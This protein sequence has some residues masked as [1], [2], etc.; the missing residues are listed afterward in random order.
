MSPI[1]YVTEVHSLMFS[2]ENLNCIWYDVV[3]TTE[4]IVRFSSTNRDVMK[5]DL[6]SGP[7]ISCWARCGIFRRDVKTSLFFWHKIFDH[8]ACLSLYLLFGSP[9]LFLLILHF[10]FSLTHALV[11]RISPWQEDIKDVCVLM[12]VM[13]LAK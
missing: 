7:A 6:S 8:Q 3:I 2:E 4:S 10:I 13:Y 11:H 1:C 5:T 12:E 9:F